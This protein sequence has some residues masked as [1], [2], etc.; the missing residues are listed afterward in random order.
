MGV[1]VEIRCFLPS[2]LLASKK[3]SKLGTEAQFRK[4]LTK[5]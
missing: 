1:L 4:W 5:K 3:I 2:L